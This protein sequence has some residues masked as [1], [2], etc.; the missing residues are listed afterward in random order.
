MKLITGLGNP[1]EK[2]A[3]TRHNIGFMVVDRF[4]RD[5]LPLA[6]SLDAWKIMKSFEGNICKLNDLIVLK[7]E[8]FM[9]RS[10]FAIQKVSS[11]YKIPLSEIWVVYDDID[12]PLGKVRIRIGGAS[13]G[14]RGIESILEHLGKSEFIR[15]RLGIG[16][17][18]MEHVKTMD[19]NLHRKD[20]EQYVISPFRDTEAG[21]LKKLIKNGVEAL[22]I[23]LTKGI[24]AA[25]NRF[26]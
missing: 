26:N 9:N 11:Y 14:H 13:A 22:E 3:H 10:G 25:M 4:I 17:G 7:P 20:I 2:Y 24:E 15:F 12:L 19:Q 21:E 1:G 23:A 18:K 16:R 6:P 5:R 8:T